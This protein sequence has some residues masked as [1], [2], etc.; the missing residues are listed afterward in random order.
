[1]QTDSIHVFGYL[2]LVRHIISQLMG[3]VKNKLLRQLSAALERRLNGGLL[4]M[5]VLISLT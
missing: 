2:K 5:K 3:L 4:L 1:M